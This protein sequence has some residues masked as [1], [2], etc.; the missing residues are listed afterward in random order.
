MRKTGALSAEK[1]LINLSPD[2]GQLNVGERR[3]EESKMF[4]KFLPR[5]FE[6]VLLAHI[7]HPGILLWAVYQ[8]VLKYK[9]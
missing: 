5:V 7:P 3:R 9:T 8:L 1:D 6:A 2:T 4:P